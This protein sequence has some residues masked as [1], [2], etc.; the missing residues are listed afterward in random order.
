MFVDFILVYKLGNK[1]ETQ[2]LTNKHIHTLYH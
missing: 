2:K 1:N